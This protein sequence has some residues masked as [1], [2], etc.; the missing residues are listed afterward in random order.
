[1]GVWFFFVGED[2]KIKIMIWYFVSRQMSQTCLRRATTTFNGE[3]S[4]A[5]QKPAS[6]I[7]TEGGGSSAVGMEVGA[8]R[9]G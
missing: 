3:K 1:M 9:H 4:P 7:I 2:R 8:V 6:R 5:H